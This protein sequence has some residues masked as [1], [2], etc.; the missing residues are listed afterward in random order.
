MKP[1]VFVARGLPLDTR[2]DVL[3][4]EFHVHSAILKMKSN[5]FFKFMDSPDKTVDN[6]SEFKYEWISRIDEDGSW[7][8]VANDPSKVRN[9]PFTRSWSF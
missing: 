6:K 3:G 1:I 7:A 8:L 5:F 9:L 2:L 4:T